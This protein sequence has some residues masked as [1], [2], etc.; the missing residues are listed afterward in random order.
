MC[1]FRCAVTCVRKVCRLPEAV[2]SFFWNCGKFI[3]AAGASQKGIDELMVQLTSRNAQLEAIN[4]LMQE[5]LAAATA[6]GKSLASAD[7]Q[8]NDLVSQLMA[9]DT[10]VGQLATAVTSKLESGNAAIG[11]LTTKLQASNTTLASLTTAYGA[12][13]APTAALKDTATAV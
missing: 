6:L 9:A 10:Q 1:G 4:A 5:R 3:M 7:T 11:S 12:L 2:C 8:I 13:T